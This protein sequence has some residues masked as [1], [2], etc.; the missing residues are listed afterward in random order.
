MS[1]ESICDI[2]AFGQCRVEAGWCDT[3]D[4]ELKRDGRRA[5]E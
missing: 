4:L 1:L 2:S 3:P 5:G